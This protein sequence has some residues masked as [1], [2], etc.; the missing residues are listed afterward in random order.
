[1]GKEA[2]K[3]AKKDFDEVKLI[4]KQLVVYKELLHH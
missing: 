2:F 4:E 3:K 1:M